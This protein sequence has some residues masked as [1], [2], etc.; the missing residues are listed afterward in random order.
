MGDPAQT[1]AHSDADTYLNGSTRGGPMP[2]PFALAFALLAPAAFAATELTIYNNNLALVKDRREIDLPKGRSSFSWDGVA[3]TIE[4]TSAVFGS[5]TAWA[6]EQNYRFDLVSRSV[7]LAKYLGKEVDLVQEGLVQD[8][9]EVSNGIRGQILSIEGERITSFAS[10]GRILLDPP[11]RVVLPSLPEG[12]LVKPTLVL[13]L[14]ADKGGRTD[15]E[16]RYLCSGLSWRAD[17]VA[18]TDSTGSSVDL[19]GLVTLENRSGTSYPGATLKLMAGD[20]NRWR[21]PARQRRY[22][23][24]DYPQPMLS[25]MPM[26]RSMPAPPQFQEQGLME[27]HLYELQRP[28]DILDKEQKQVSFLS[29]QDASSR[30]RFVFDESLYSRYW[31]WTRESDSRQGLKCGVILEVPNRKDR[32]LGLPLPKGV[33]RVYTRDRSGSL[34]FVGEDG[35]DHTPS[36]DTLRLALGQAFDLRG[37]RTVE[38]SDQQ[39]R[40]KTETVRIDLRNAKSEAVEIDVVEH[41]AW[42][43]WRVKENSLPFEKRDASTIVFKVKVPAGGQ[44]S[45]RYT[46]HASWK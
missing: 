31:W 28:T 26:E 20:V 8:G 29:A 25:S 43:T 41:Q 2:R 19:D 30:K 5:P 27:Y 42:P 36:G 32:H 1:V 13:D 11:G 37:S 38:S 46:Y 39:D 6:L 24:D 22:E 10:G 3:Q 23:A 14:Q 4:T 15:A 18:I 7:L 16:L 12:L 40:Q 33:V 45:V 44:A 9:R 21:E 34:Q 35:I 17:Y